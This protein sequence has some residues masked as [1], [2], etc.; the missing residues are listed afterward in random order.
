MFY[1]AVASFINKRNFQLMKLP[2]G[3]SDQ[4]LKNV[5]YNKSLKNLPDEKWKSI[6]GFENY[7][8]SNYGRVKRL[9]RRFQTPLGYEYTLAELILQP[10]FSKNFNNYLQNYTYNVQCKI[11][12][13]GKAYTKSLGRLVY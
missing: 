1:R 6:E 13:E 8:I 2:I 11:S 10:L 3:L 7:E 4:Y 12:R 9:K 5:L